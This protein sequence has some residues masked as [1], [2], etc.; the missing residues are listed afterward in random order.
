MIHGGSGDFHR[1]P[2][3]LGSGMAG[4]REVIW[5]QPLTVTVPCIVHHIHLLHD[6]CAFRNGRV[7]R[8]YI[9]VE[10]L[11]GGSL[12]QDVYRRSCKEIGLGLEGLKWCMRSKLQV[13][14]ILVSGW[15]GGNSSQF[16]ILHTP[17]TYYTMYVPLWI[18]E[19]NATRCIDELGVP[20]VSEIM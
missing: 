18:T 8:T 13:P 14:P 7:K 1:Y 2:L 20:W 17:F 11:V 19:L 5:D 6:V 9:D 4:A 15:F 10:E 3:I 12:G 16:L